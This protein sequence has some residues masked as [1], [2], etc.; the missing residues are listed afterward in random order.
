[1][2]HEGVRYWSHEEK[3]KFRFTFKLTTEPRFHPNVV[4]IVMNIS[5]WSICY[6]S[7][8]FHADK[9]PRCE[10]K[11]KIHLPFRNFPTSLDFYEWVTY[12][13]KCRLYMRMTKDDLREN[14]VL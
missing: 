6:Y 13:L 2:P 11:I 4:L 9:H 5:S 14:S 7:N 3:I 10:P 12:R 1:M 8:G